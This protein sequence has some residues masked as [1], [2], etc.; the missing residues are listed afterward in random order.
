MNNDDIL[1]GIDEYERQQR[2]V[3]YLSTFDGKLFTSSVNQFT[4]S[5]I[6]SL[7]P[8]KSQMLEALESGRAYAWKES[9]STTFLSLNIEHFKDEQTLHESL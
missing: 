7:F 5:V 3:Y 6:I 4:W 2:A 9:Y 1:T 8:E